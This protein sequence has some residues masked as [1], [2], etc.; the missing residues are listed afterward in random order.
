MSLEKEMRA[1]VGPIISDD[2]TE[3]MG[4]RTSGKVKYAPFPTSSSA[5]IDTEFSHP[6]SDTTLVQDPD[7]TVASVSLTVTN[8]IGER[9][10][11]VPESTTI[12]PV[13][14]AYST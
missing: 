12:E 11:I 5:R 6:E 9:S 8:R 4:T 14:R 1:L 3:E 2:T 13:K 7:P 10:D